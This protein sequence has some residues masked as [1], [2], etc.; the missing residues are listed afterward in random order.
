VKILLAE[1]DR[2]AQ[3]LV[4]TQLEKWG[5]E[6]L[7]CEDG[8]AAWKVLQS[9]SSPGLAVVDWMMPKLDGVEVCRRVRQM[10]ASSYTYILLLTT[11]NQTEDVITG[12]EAGADDYLT[13]P[14]QPSEMRARLLVGERI[15]D[16][17]DRLLRAQAELRQRADHDGLTGLWNRRVILDLLLRE[18]SRA[19]RK[20]RPLSVVM[21]DLDHFKNIN[22]RYGHQAGDEVLLEAAR[23]MTTTLRAYD[24]I[25]RFGGEEFLVVLPG[26]DL[27]SAREAAER[28]R[29]SIESAPIATEEEE[30]PVTASFGLATHDA[31]DSVSTQA[32]IR[33]ADDAL[34]RAKRQGRN[35]VEQAPPLHLAG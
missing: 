34:Y 35:Q 15:L 21:V 1:D 12:L 27:K 6:V 9:E 10:R 31:Q 33:A 19:K 8:E 25:G 30:I 17:Q 32:L 7:T 20:K 2:V 28:M 29:Q 24:L 22:D 4:S 3:R 11:R 13:K 14:V 16:L 23:R 26:C 5:Y 18:L